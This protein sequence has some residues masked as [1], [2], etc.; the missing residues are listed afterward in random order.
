MF[1]NM[2]ISMRLGLGFG[3]VILLLVVM[4][5]SSLNRMEILADLT[6]KLYN[7]PFQVSNAVLKV[8]AGIIAM[9]RSMKDVAQARDP[10]LFEVALKQVNAHERDVYKHFE[11]IADRFLGA[12]EMYEK[13]L[14]T[15]K[16]WKPIREEATG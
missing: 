3:V 10:A 6:L 7:H 5:L 9:H 13:P 8:D 15:F 12:K 4:G 1:K 16:Q 11:V 2:K 14:E